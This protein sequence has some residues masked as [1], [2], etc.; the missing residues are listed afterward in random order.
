MAT[1]LPHEDAL[2]IEALENQ[3]RSIGA[4]LHD[5][6]C[7]TLAG[8]GL[9]IQTLLRSAEAGRPLPA[10]QVQLL[11]KSIE[12]A[13]DQLRAMSHRFDPARLEGPGL[14]TSLQELT[15]TPAGRGEFQCE[16]PVFVADQQIA[17]AV[18]RIAQECWQRALGDLNAEQVRLSLSQEAGVIELALSCRGTTPNSHELVTEIAQH[19]ARVLNGEI[20]VSREGGAVTMRC[21]IPL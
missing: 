4:E 10:E 12:E 16:K 15:G 1:I 14:M 8:T 21:R 11:K 20:N 13:I 17:L 18:Y 2:F 6:V 7:Q 9:L 3:L 19:R 5:G